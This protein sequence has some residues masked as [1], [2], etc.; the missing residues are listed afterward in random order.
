MFSERYLSLK[1]LRL[2]A[3]IK[4]YESALH[5]FLFYYFEMLLLLC[6]L[7]SSLS[8]A[9]KVIEQPNLR[10]IGPSGI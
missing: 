8:S 9:I 4:H 10:M 1:S 5:I 2:F 6:I 7:L 3:V